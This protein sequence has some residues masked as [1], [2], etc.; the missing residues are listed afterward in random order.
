MGWVL[1]SW[2]PVRLLAGAS[3]VALVA[4]VALVSQG[5]LY[6][7][8][9]VLRV[10][11]MIAALAVLALALGLAHRPPGG[12]SGPALGASDRWNVVTG[13]T[14]L[15]VLAVSAV[16]LFSP[17]DRPGLPK[18]ACPNA[19]TQKTAYVGLTAG[20]LGNNSRSGPGRAHPA[21]GR[22][23]ADCSVGFSD[24]CLGDPIL[25]DTGSTKH[26]QWVTNRWLRIAKQPSS[27]WSWRSWTAETL[28]DEQSGDQFITDAYVIP[29]TPYEGLRR[30]D[31]KVC[32]H[33]YPAGPA[34]L[35]W[36]AEKRYPGLKTPDV[37]LSAT[38]DHAVNIGF[39][40]Y[41][42]PGEG[43]REQDVV[44]PLYDE[45][46]S[47]AQNPGR[48]LPRSGNRKTITWTYGEPLRARL[49]P[50]HKGAAHVLL[51]AIPC[52]SDN[53]HD[54]L[55]KA[56]LARY[57]ITPDGPP[58]KAALTLARYDRAVLGRLALAAC[59]ANV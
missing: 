55:R 18:A 14:G 52:V 41:L 24:Y 2:W 27:W 44:L 40:V 59:Q 26:Q 28:S 36:F 33:Q 3:V 5:V 15:L 39:A 49:L 54:D 47:A 37:E 45:S 31:D 4:R 43:F 17:I 34:A 21:N 53:L 29:A 19:R 42:P 10:D 50:G 57:D 12:A 1:R 8:T 32:G 11:G 38:S 51:M 6:G 48:V 46:L 58:H 25:D 23:P 22:F 13:V 35:G 56:A 7:R 30:A 9:Q 20:D 16:S